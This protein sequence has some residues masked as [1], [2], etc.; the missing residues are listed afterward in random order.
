MNKKLRQAI[1][2]LGKGKYVGGSSTK[3]GSIYNPLPFPGCENIPC[4]RPNSPERWAIISTYTFFRDKTVLDLGCATGYFSFMARRAGAKLVYGVDYDSK[5]IAVCKAASAAYG[6]GSIQFYEGNTGFTSSMK[7]ESASVA[8]AMAVLNWAGRDKAEAW[9]KW[10]GSHAGI[11]WLEMPIQ[12]DG[13][14]PAKWLKSEQDIINWTKRHSGYRHVKKKGQTRGPH[15]G[16][17][18]PLFKCW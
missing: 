15:G 13:K 1:A 11:L 6:V 9:L 14:R 2:Q 4:H 12:G 8:F 10:A 3:A 5:A 7:L 17:W 18:R 16:R